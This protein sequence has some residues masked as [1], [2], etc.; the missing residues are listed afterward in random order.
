MS[1]MLYKH[2]G[3]HQIHG[4]SFDYIVVE[5]GEVA[6]KVKEGWAKST[7]EA[8]KPA[9]KPDAKRSRKVKATE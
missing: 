8:K 7:D 4:D 3:K 2:P 5:E 1:V 9:K 6:A